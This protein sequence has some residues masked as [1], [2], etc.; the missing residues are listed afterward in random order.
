MPS[1]APVALAIGV[2]YVLGRSH[3]LRWAVLLG[4]AAAT[5]QVGGLSKQALQRGTEM[6]RANPDVAKL[7]ETATGLLQAGRSA[8][9][10]AMQSRTEALTETLGDKAGELGST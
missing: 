10:S 5:G 7:T 3:K 8:A 9:V 2:G 1:A 4:T 6:L